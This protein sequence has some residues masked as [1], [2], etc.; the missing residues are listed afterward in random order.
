M[1]RPRPGGRTDGKVDFG[2]EPRSSSVRP[3][4]ECACA[5]DSQTDADGRTDRRRMTINYYATI[6]SS[7]PSLPPSPPPLARSRSPR[8]EDAAMYPSVRPSVRPSIH[9]A[10]F[11]SSGNPASR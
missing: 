4:V 2:N 9:R 5:L 6:V 1:K 3:S 11:R 8:E 10:R 7:P